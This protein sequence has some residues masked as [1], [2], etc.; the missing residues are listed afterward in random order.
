MKLVATLE[1]QT[2]C[3]VWDID[4]ILLI[5]HV[6]TAASLRQSNGQGKRDEPTDVEFDDGTIPIQELVLVITMNGGYRQLKDPR[7][8]EH[9]KARQ[10]E[11]FGVHNGRFEFSDQEIGESIVQP[12]KWFA[13]Q[14]IVPRGTF[15]VSIA[16]YGVDVAG[17][18]QGIE[19][20]PAMP[21]NPHRSQ[22]MHGR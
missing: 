4:Y 2:S 11:S 19:R 13:K 5:P 16:I 6:Q 9:V 15:V 20:R 21:A 12:L 8:Q 1:H 18:E 22:S 14:R 7:A 3:P 17:G 10:G